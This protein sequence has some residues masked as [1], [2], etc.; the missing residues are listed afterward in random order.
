MQLTEVLT[1]HILI[2]I[3]DMASS[4]P[5]CGHETRALR[6]R[7][8]TG[9]KHQQIADHARLGDQR[10]GE[11]PLDRN[12]SYGSS[13]IYLRIFSIEWPFRTLTLVVSLA[14]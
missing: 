6:H 14:G 8:R 9:Q 3:S 7:A 13:V 5:R 12:S 11:G 2:D 4:H 1:T 10:V